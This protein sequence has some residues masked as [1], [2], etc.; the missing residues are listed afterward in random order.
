MEWRQHR[1]AHVEAMASY[2]PAVVYGYKSSAG[3]E[4]SAIETDRPDT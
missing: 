4:N 2:W 1:A 3:P